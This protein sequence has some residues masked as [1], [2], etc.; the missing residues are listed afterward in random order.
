MAD[1]Y[2]DLTEKCREIRYQMMDMI[3]HLGVGHVGGSLSVVETMVLLY[4]KHM[5]N[6]DPANP[7][8]A[9]R[10]RFI[11]SKGHAGPTLYTILADKGYFPR[12]M[13]YTLNQGGTSLPSHP[14]MN[15]TPGIDMTTGSLGQGLSCAVGVAAGAK[16]KKDGARVYSILGDGESQEGQIWEAAMYAAQLKLDNLIAFTDYNNMQIDG[17]IDQINDVAPL[18]KKWEAFGWNTQVVDG[19]NLEQIDKAIEVALKVAGQ[20]CMII[21]K[22]TKGKGVSFIEAAGTG[23]HNMPVPA[24]KRN[25]ALEELRGGGEK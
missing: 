5:R 19:H 4:Y 13:L 20:P 2:G 7:K 24:D 14:D 17:T 25:Q 16:L 18:D 11:L 3:G 1:N 22:T 12:D 21:L 23:N 6:I 15:R 10:D 8:K 9:G